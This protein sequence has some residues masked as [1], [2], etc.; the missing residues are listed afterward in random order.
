MLVV[1]PLLAVTV[2]AAATF[3]QT[4]LPQPAPDKPSDQ[5]KAADPADKMAG[6]IHQKL[7][8]QGFSDIQI[9][10]ASYLVSAKDK[11][12]NSFILLIA[13]DSTTVLAM[14]RSA[15]DNDAD[16]SGPSTAEMP[17]KSS[18]KLIQ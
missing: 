3:A 10:P 17:D 8:S 1:A 12:G 2:I 9:L 18:D 15:L 16:S 4:S 14:E 13:P 6:Q 11:D 7:S 5:P